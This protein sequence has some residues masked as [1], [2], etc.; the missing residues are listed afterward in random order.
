MELAG[1]IPM[2]EPGVVAAAEAIL[3]EW[4]EMR[5]ISLLNKDMMEGRRMAPPRM[6]L[7]EAAELVPLE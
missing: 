3:V 6:D 4:E 5:I 7:A 1:L 2:Q